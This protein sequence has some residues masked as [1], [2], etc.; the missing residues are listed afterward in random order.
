M[1]DTSQWER[2]WKNCLSR[3]QQEVN[4]QERLKVEEGSSPIRPGPHRVQRTDLSCFCGEVSNSMFAEVF[5]SHRSVKC[6]KPP[7]NLNS[8]PRRCVF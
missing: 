8:S 6:F 2:R 3:P 1:C 7:R 5:F 4:L